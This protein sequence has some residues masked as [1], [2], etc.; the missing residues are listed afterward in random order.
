MNMKKIALIAVMALFT[1]ATSAQVKLA[2]VNFNELVTLMPESDNARSTMEA[3]QKEANE[4]YQSMVE[5]AQT[6]YSEYQQKQST[7]TA[8]I[9]DSKEKELGDIQNR[10]Q[11]FQQSIQQELQQ[12][13]EQLMTPIYD[14]AR[15]AIEKIAKAGGYVFVFDSSQYVYVDPSQ[16]KDLTPEA[17]KALNIPEGRTIESLQKELQAKQESAASSTGSTTGTAK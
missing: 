1:L 15:K 8:A 11:E 3:A 9:R 10:I 16:S 2:H 12:Q 5:E 14:K 17:R 7:W 4:T 6:K 13:N